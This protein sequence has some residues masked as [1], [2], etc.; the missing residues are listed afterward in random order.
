MAGFIMGSGARARGLQPCLA[1]KMCKEKNNALKVFVIYLMITLVEIFGESASERI[2][3]NR[4]IIDEVMSWQKT[5][6]YFWLTV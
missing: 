6:A 1:S 5:V 2:L 4:L 3:K